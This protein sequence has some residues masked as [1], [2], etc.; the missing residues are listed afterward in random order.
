MASAI[1]GLAA[2]LDRLDDA[3]AAELGLG[4]SD[5]AAMEIVSRH[6]TLTAGQLAEQLRLTTGAVTG[7]VDRMEGMGY[8]RRQNDPR[9]GRKVMVQLTAKA[10]AGEEKA[11]DPIGR[12]LQKLLATY[13]TEDLVLIADFLEKTQS[14]VHRVLSR[15]PLI[16]MA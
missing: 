7:V 11:F 10:R 15:D 3:A 9:D 16:R 5:L 6:G 4:R 13:R 1:R 12:D 14:V 2:A 8:F